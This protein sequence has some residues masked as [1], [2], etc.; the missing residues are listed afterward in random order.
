MFCKHF[1]WMISGIGAVF[2]TKDKAIAYWQEYREVAISVY[3]CDLVRTVDEMGDHCVMGKHCKYN[4]PIDPVFG[5]DDVK[6]YYRPVR[7]RMLPM[8]LLIENIA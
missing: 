8:V 4:F 7:I 6:E 3:S 1:T 2:T 5:V